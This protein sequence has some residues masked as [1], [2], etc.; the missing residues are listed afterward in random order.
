MIL[1]RTALQ[2]TDQ[3]HKTIS[4]VDPADYVRVAYSGG[5]AIP[6]GIALS[7]DQA[8]VIVTDAQSRFSWSFQVAD[9]G[10]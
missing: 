5:I 8:F 2:L 3:A 4:M 1:P 7:P 9:D 10:H 6:A